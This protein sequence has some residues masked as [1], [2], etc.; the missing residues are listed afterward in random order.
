MDFEP[1]FL[2][3]SPP[4]PPASS[5]HSSHTWVFPFSKHTRRPLHMLFTWLRWH[6]T[7]VFTYFFLLVFKAHPF[8]TAPPGTQGHLLIPRQDRPLL[9][10]QCPSLRFCG[11]SD[12]NMLELPI[13]WPVPFTSQGPLLAHMHTILGQWQL[14]SRSCPMQGQAPAVG[15]HRRKS[16]TGLSETHKD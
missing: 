10:F 3:L 9:S 15:R 16:V 12:H 13:S 2:A 6:S 7:L 4:P 14:H 11:C 5:P 1:F 8:H